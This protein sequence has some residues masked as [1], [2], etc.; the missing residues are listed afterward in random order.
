[1][2]RSKHAPQ[3]ER[4]VVAYT[5]VST[6]EQ[7]ELGA[8]LETQE[9]RIRA[10]C[11]AMQ[12][13]EPEIVCDAGI[14]AKTLRRN[15]MEELLARVRRREVSHVVVAKLDR[16][17]RSLKDL[18]DLI[19]TFK[20]HHVAFVSVSES[21]DTTSATGEFFVHMLG[22]LAQLEARRI[23]S[24][25]SEVLTQMRRCG[26]AYSGQVPFGYRRSGDVLLPDAHEQRAIAWMRKRVRGGESLSAVAR[27]LNERGISPRR[28]TTWDH[29]S[30]RAVLTSRIATEAAA[31]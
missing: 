15:G 22:A 10:Y 8:S 31:S 16:A 11:V 12:L 6:Q 19:E 4:R 9:H 30:V 26:K 23:G 1:M 27:A 17:T 25:T 29:S 13:P 14:S 5:R 28:A 21:L 20:K 24:R 7:S 2:G 18:I 3:P